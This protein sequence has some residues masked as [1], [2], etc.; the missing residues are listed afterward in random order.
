MNNLDYETILHVRENNPE[1]Q[2]HL[3]ANKFHF[4]GQCAVMLSALQK[5]V[6]LTTRSAML[7]YNISDPRRRIKDLIDAGV[8]INSEFVLD[9]KGEKTRF[10]RWWIEEAVKNK[11]PE[12]VKLSKK[13][14]FHNQPKLF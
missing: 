4:T 8:E 1:S 5:G 7:D 6:V 3:N 13:N 2:N 12:P 11:K 14:I 10:K 9:D